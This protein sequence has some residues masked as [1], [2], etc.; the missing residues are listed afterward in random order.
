MHNIQFRLLPSG[1]FLSP[2]LVFLSLSRSLAF[3]S[4]LSL[5][6]S[7]SRTHNAPRLNPT[8]QPRGGFRLYSG[9]FKLSS[10]WFFS[11]NASWRHSYLEFVRAFPENWS[12]SLSFS[13]LIFLTGDLSIPPVPSSFVW[14]VIKLATSD[15]GFNWFHSVCTDCWRTSRIASRHVVSCRTVSHNFHGSMP[16]NDISCSEFFRGISRFSAMWEMFQDITIFC[17]DIIICEREQICL[18]II[19]K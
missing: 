6:L 2:P 1:T 16:Q 11:I 4:S 14:R 5:F 8:P 18:K 12:F 7:P 13:V 17:V 15:G 3:L 10:K 9:K 19:C